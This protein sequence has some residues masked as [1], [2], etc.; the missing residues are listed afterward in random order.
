[1]IEACKQFLIDRVQEIT[2]SDQGQPFTPDNIFFS[3]LP[4]DFLKKNR[5]AACLLVA[6]DK[7]KKNGRLMS[8]V[9]DLEAHV[10]VRTYKRFERKIMVRCILYASSFEDL[11][12]KKK[13]EIWD[14]N[15]FKGFVDQLE[16]NIAKHKV[17]ADE[18]NNAVKITLEDSIRP[19]DL[20]EGRQ[21]LK[22]TPH[23]AIVRVEFKGGIYVQKQVPI[24]K[25]VDIQPEFK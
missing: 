4:R 15:A 16:Q 20:E 6:M 7:K 17:I 10:F 3:P 25:S 8:N 19:W 14:L 13:G 5:F 11:W 12:S 22:K 9:R 2:D 18:L 21:S 1:M 24:I 23:K